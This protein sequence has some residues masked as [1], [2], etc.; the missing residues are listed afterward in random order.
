MELIFMMTAMLA[1]LGPIVAGRLR[2]IRIAPPLLVL[3]DSLVPAPL[4][5]SWTCPRSELHS[6]PACGFDIR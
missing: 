5:A 4:A 2:C 6:S 1:L 3:V